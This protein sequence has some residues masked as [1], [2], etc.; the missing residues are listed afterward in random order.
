MPE[1]AKLIEIWIEQDGGDL[2]IATHWVNYTEW[3]GIAADRTT[4]DLGNHRE[5][6]LVI[7]PM[8]DR[9]GSASLAL[10]CRPVANWLQRLWR[11]GRAKLAPGPS[12]LRFAFGA[13]SLVAIGW[14]VGSSIARREMN[15][16]QASAERLGRQLAQEKILRESL[17]QQ[18]SQRAPASMDI[19]R[20]TPDEVQVRTNEQSRKPV[21]H[22]KPNQTLVTIQLP[23]AAVKNQKYKAVLTEFLK[24]QEILSEVFPAVKQNDTES[25]IEFQLPS[26]LVQDGQYYVITVSYLTDRGV[27]EP[28]R[29]F[30]FLVLK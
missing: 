24:H 20:L 30:T 17:Q 10:S 18:L 6:E 9:A 29:S 7:T 23:V 5:I 27:A 25:A 21:V 16:Q 11:T 13:A 28:Y 1:G 22:L 12:L 8:A 2:L 3:L 14:V 4:I 15:R 26:N 19:Y